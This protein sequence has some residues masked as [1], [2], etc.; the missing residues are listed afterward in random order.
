MGRCWI[1]EGAGYGKVLDM[2]RCWINKINLI[3]G[4]S[5]HEEDIFLATEK[6]CWLIEGASFIERRLCM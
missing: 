4:C 5:V 1:W 2:G 6:L 3:Y